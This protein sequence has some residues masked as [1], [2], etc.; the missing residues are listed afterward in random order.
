MIKVNV[1]TSK[2]AVRVREHNSAFSVLLTTDK[3]EKGDKGDKGDAFRYEDFTEEQLEAFFKRFRRVLTS[4]DDLDDVIQEGVYYYSTASIPK[5]S[6]YKNA[7][8]VKVDYTD[9]DTTRVVQS[10]TRYGVAG[11]SSFRTKYAGSWNVWTEVGLKSDAVCSAGDI[12]DGAEL[13]TLAGYTT[14]SSTVV[15]L[16]LPL[17]KKI[18]LSS[19]TGVEVQALNA[20]LRG[21][22]GYLG[23]TKTNFCDGTYSLWCKPFENGVSIK[24]TKS[25]AF[26]NAVNNTPVSAQINSLKLKFT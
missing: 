1:V 18:D 22:Q 15:Y 10:V 25:E 13:E 17:S 5:N 26:S 16:F 23:S 9:D 14:T 21:V 24:I 11:A 7:G 6:P 4:E 12:F 19:V 20:T 3:G 8:V 2:V